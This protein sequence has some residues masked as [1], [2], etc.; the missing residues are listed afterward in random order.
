MSDLPT[1]QEQASLTSDPGNPTK[2][3]PSIADRKWWTETVETYLSPI[4]RFVRARVPA[5]AVDDL[6][7]D[8]FV[9][10]AGSVSQFDPQKASVWTWFVGI[11]RK[12]IADY[13]RTHNR[14]S[15]L[16]IATRKLASDV[17]DIQKLL[18]TSTPLPDKACETEELRLVVRAA[19]NSLEP[20]HQACLVARYDKELS[21]DEVAQLMN[22]SPS[23]ANSMLYRARI[24]FRRAMNR[25]LSGKAD[26][27]E[28]TK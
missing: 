20:R 27:E 1:R 11:T 19:L 2:S 21:L 8:I 14:D 9:S 6:V 24:Q 10:A 5:D 22:L 18:A 23:A 13:Y 12:K 26:I 25:L 4:Y 16:N 17:D 3:V 15:L 28:S 7:Q